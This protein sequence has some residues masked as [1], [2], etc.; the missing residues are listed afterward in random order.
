[1]YMAPSLTSNDEN[2][3]FIVLFQFRSKKTFG[4]VMNLYN[5]KTTADADAEDEG[6]VLLDIN[7]YLKREALPS[8]VPVEIILVP[9]DLGTE[10]CRM[11]EIVGT[12]I[13]VHIDRYDRLMEGLLNVYFLDSVFSPVNLSL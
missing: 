8:I 2:C 6:D 10:G 12:V 9:T 13:V 4:Q 3:S 5:N 11:E 1:V 7:L